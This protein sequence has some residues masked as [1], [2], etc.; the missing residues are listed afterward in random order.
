LVWHIRHSTYLNPLILNEYISINKNKKRFSNAVPLF[1]GV[2]QGSVLGPLSS[3]IHS[4]KLDH[5][6]YADDSQV[7]I[8]L[9]TSDTDISLKHLGDCLSDISGWM[10]N[11][12]LRLNANKTV[13]III[14]T[15]RQRRKLTC[16][17][18]TN[19]LSHSIT[20]SDTVRNLRVTFD[21]DFNFGKHIPL[22]CHCCFYHIRDLRRIRCYI[23]LSVT[24]TIA[25]AL[26]TSRLD[27]CNSLL[28]NIASQ[29]ILKLQ[30]VQ[31]CLARV[32]TRSPQFSH[33]SP[34]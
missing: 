5:Q 32:V 14:G 4:H 25:T 2:S 18:P 11:N 9:S 22:T 8:S 10:T 26:V 31:N 27:Y 17:F 34:F 30:C 23:S 7:Y 33:L 15:S 3:L 13:F 24:K 6:L 1:C 28:Y 16:F 29:D 21:S 20:P 19:I 12:K